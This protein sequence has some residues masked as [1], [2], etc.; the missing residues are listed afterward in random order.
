MKLTAGFSQRA[1]A[2]LDR[3]RNADKRKPVPTM[4]F[5]VS[6]G[7]SDAPTSTD[8]APPGR[9]AA[10]KKELGY[11][12]LQ[13]KNILLF[14]TMLVADKAGIKENRDLVKEQK[15]PDATMPLDE[16]SVGTITFDTSKGSTVVQ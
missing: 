6:E 7:V 2:E 9:L 11:G 13:I 1:G 16:K 12:L 8:L 10:S 14:P 4:S 15:T 3:A 5:P